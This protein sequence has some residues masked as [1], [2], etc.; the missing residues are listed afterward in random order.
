MTRPRCTIFSSG[1]SA[2]P[3]RGLALARFLAVKEV[4]M[5]KVLMFLVAALFLIFGSAAQ[6]QFA[7][8]LFDVGQA[9]AILLEFNSGTILIDAGGEETRDDQY[10]EHLLSD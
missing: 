6:A 3:C 10:K 5:R 1:Y 4:R 9:D 8:H 7:I 2:G